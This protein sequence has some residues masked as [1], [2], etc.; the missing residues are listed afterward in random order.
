MSAAM[1]VLPVVWAVGQ[2]A[3]PSA[4]PEVY[5]PMPYEM[6]F[7]RRYTEG[8][9]QRYVRL[10]M[11][12]GRVP[13]LLGQEMFRGKVTSYQVGSFVDALIFVHDVEKCIAKLD[14]EQQELISR[15]AVQQYT[16]N[17]TAG[18]LG[19]RPRTLV[20]RYGAA[21]DRLTR[22]FLSVQL[23]EPQRCCQGG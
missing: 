4:A 19:I 21:V 22:I 18:L 10:S 12:A 11:E 7:Y 6:V 1:A 13:S 3:P 5:E 14:G 8:I 9:L 2:A 23:L 20:R 16:L 17:E 15:I